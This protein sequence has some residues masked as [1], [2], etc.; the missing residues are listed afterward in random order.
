MTSILDVDDVLRGLRAADVFW[1]DLGRDDDHAL[2][3][4]LT[5]GSLAVLGAGPG[6][7][8][9]IRERLRISA[10]TRTAVAGPGIEPRRRSV[11]D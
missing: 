3:A 11:T 8:G 7:A 4:V 2:E 6:L 10:D 9:R 5:P 1:R